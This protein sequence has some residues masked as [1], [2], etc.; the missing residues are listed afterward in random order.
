MKTYKAF[1]Q[2]LFTLKI[3]GNALGLSESELQ[4]LEIPDRVIEKEV[5]ITTEHGEE[6]K[7]NA[8]RIQFDNSRGP[9]KGGIRFHPDANK[10]EVKL[11]A[12]L[13]ALKC[14]VVDIP[15]GGA[16]G[17]VECNPKELSKND[18]E[19]LARGWMRSMADFVGSDKDIPAPDVYTNPEIMGYMMDEFE[20][21]KGRSEPGVIT[22]KPI[23]LG[24]SQGRDTATAQGGIYVLEEL[25]KILKLRKNRLRIAV[26]GFGNAGYNA[27]RIL[28]DLDY[29]IVA[30]SDS[31]GGVYSKNGVDPNLL[32]EAKQN[33]TTVQDLYCDGSVCDSKKLLED[34]AEIISSEDI[35]TCDCDILIP[36]ALDNQI[37]QDNAK[38]VKAKIILE[39]ANGPTTPEADTILREK[40][41]FVIPD[42]L[43]NAGG[44]TVSYFEWVQNKMNLY[45]TKEEVQEKLNRIM[46]NAFNDV[47]VN[48]RENNISLREAAFMLG[49]KRVVEVM[50]SRGRV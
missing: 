4:S 35:I 18:V 23:D 50:R 11:L 1:E 39:L 37:T 2:Y 12:A 36:A 33:K 7:F 22:G 15:L 24:G 6:K 13:M 3:A 28:H 47:W 44:V 9:Y 41:V 14:A 34:K 46:V 21:I 45:W 27:V 29:R 26:Q 25:I 5:H 48:S 30:V 20:K 42:I 17:G 43:A 10:D 8:Y 31:K 19:A 38:S 40:D 32:Y 49:I 16:K